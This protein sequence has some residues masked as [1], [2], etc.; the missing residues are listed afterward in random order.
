MGQRFQLEGEGP[1]AYERYLVPAFFAP[2]AEQLLA[3]APAAPGQ[4]VL[5][6]ACGTGVVARLAAAQVGAGGATTGVDINHGMIDVARQVPAAGATTWHTADATS[7]PLPDK[8]FDVAYCQ[9]G[10]QFLT[11]R[12]RALRE[13]HRVVKPAGR[14]AIAV[15]RA[16]EHSPAVAAFVQVLQRHAGDEAAAMMRAPFA[17][18]DRDEIR[19]L[20][21]SAGFD[22]T[23]VRIGVVMVRFRSAEEFLHHE[24]VS[25]PLAGP[26]GALDDDRYRA[27]ARNLTHALGPYADDGGIV[28]PVQTWLATAHKQETPH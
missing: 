6:V 5:D 25:S 19:R 17:W 15:W 21:V 8:V 23:T 9:Q 16:L 13:L 18:S 24:V 12:P 22:K 11:D 4:R 1:H 26:V 3:L 10:L 28:L 7:L 20:L 14:V 2:C 27:L